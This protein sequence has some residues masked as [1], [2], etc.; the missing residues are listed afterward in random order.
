MH[1]LGRLSI[2]TSTLDE[3]SDISRPSSHQAQQTRNLVTDSIPSAVDLI[4]GILPWFTF[5]VCALIAV[6]GI[7]VHQSLLES[8]ACCF[9]D[10]DRDG[11]D[12]YHFCDSSNDCYTRN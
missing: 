2:I 7:I 9:D 5:G 12:K 10:L 3:V 8:P 4:F 6:E 11:D 1:I